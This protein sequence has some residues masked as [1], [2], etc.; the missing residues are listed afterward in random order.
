[1]DLAFQC[2]KESN[3]AQVLNWLRLSAESNH[4]AQ[5]ILGLYYLLGKILPQPEILLYDKYFHFVANI[6]DTIILKTEPSINCKDFVHAR[7]WLHLSSIDKNDLATLTLATL[8]LGGYWGFQ[9]DTAKAVKMLLD[10]HERN[11]EH[12]ERYIH[13]INTYNNKEPYFKYLSIVELFLFKA[14]LCG[15]GTSK[16]LEQAERHFA[17]LEANEND[18]TL[19]KLKVKARILKDKMCPSGARTKEE[20]EKDE[21]TL[22]KL[23]QNNHPYE[24]Y[25]ITLL[26]NCMPLPELKD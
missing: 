24:Y 19:G 25:I 17:L 16:N 20:T 7:Y 9:K 5:L 15:C 21:E 14:H 22:A 4:D 13:Y 12:Y 18:N 2:R 1:V 11:K 23:D 26:D 10:I 8:H 3:N 6:V